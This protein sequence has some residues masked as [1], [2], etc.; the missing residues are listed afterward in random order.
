MVRRIC[1]YM[2]LVVLWA[3]VAVPPIYAQQD[4]QK[5]QP[6]VG[7]SLSGGGALGYAHL[8]FLQ[9]MNEAAR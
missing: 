1:R 2:L 7:V 5:N 6:K 9:A 8:G 4:C 3:M